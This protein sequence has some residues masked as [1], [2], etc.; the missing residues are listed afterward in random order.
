MH[1]EEAMITLLGDKLVFPGRSIIREGKNR[2]KIYLPKQYNH[3]LETIKE[4]DAK[5][6]VIII[7]RNKQ[8]PRPNKH[9]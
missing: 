8:Q 2:Y 5:V 1:E 4:R 7:V 6:D 3:I 9:S